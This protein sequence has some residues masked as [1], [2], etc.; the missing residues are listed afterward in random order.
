MYIH[1]HI[2][3]YDTCFVQKECKNQRSK[4]KSSAKAM[5]IRMEAMGM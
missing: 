1:I 3:I 2:Y 4:A 5:I